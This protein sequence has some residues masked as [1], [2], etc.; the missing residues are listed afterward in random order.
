[1]KLDNTTLFNQLAPNTIILT[2][3][4][5]L[6][7]TLHKLYQQYQLQQG[8]TVWETPTIMPISTWLQRTWLDYTRTQF[9]D[10]PLLLNPQQEQYVWETVLTQAKETNQLLQIAETAELAKS[11]YG[12]L[13]QWQVDLNQPIFQSSDDYQALRTWI[14]EYHRHC[15][16]LNAMDSTTLID[17]IINAIKAKKMQTPEKIILMGFNELSPQIKSLLTYC[18]HET[19]AFATERQTCFRTTLSDFESEMIAMARWAKATLIANPKATIGCVIPTLDATRDR[20]EQLF[21]QVMSHDAIPFNIS[22]GKPLLAY[23]VL[24]AA[25]Q[26]LSIQQSNLSQDKLN[27]LLTTPFIG[28]AELERIQRAKF[29]ALLRQHNVMQFNILQPAHP[30][31]TYCNF[32]YKR[33]QRYFELFNQQA[34]KQTYTEWTHVFNELLTT[35]GWPGERSLN[36]EEFQVVDQWL[37]LLNN[38]AS[39]DQIATPTLFN[40]AWQTLVKMAS[41]TV[42]QAKTPEAPIQVLGVLEAAALPFDYV[43]IA[44]MDDISWPPQPKPN[45]FIP[46]RLQRELNMPHATPERELQYCE[47]LTRQFKSCASHV[48]FSSAEAQEELELHPSPLIRDLPEITLDKLTLAPFTSPTEQIYQSRMIDTLLDDHGPAIDSQE[49]IRGGISIL[50]Q[51]AL[52]PFKAFAEWRLHAKELEQP[53]PGLRAKDRGIIIHKVLELVWK[54]LQHHAALMNMNEDALRS[55]I[56]SN[57]DTALQTYSHGRHTQ[58]QYLALEKQRLQKLIWE[59]LQVEKSRAPFTVI[60]HEKSASITLNKLQLDIR[61]DRIDAL[62][63]GKKLIIDYKTGKYNDIYAWFSERPEEPQLPVYALLDMTNTIGITFAQVFP[64]AHTFKGISHYS[65]D[66]DG[67]KLISEIKK[68]TVQSWPAQLDQWQAI[69]LKLSDDFYNG[70]ATVDPKNLPETCQYC[71]LKSLCRVNEKCLE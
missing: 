54:S 36:S 42:F 71:K 65:L 24:N 13:Q 43:W 50:K 5:R 44:G 60:T 11:A 35:L 45:P 32:L 46:K 66:I 52:C 64:G 40:Q 27:F 28:E 10:A 58:Q 33:L 19:F 37:D 63:D 29:D 31:D 38:F 41:N 9:A 18:P 56:S 8:L 25:L 12:L 23:P 26:L 22:A 14:D 47:D 62:P 3:N 57:I 48:I 55:L 1:M 21:S 53:Q 17:L 51:Q 49:K 16:H 59:W 34:S 15:R 70:V 61:I 69:L 20:I 68:A 7:A 2:P 6:S 30:I 67:I 39:L 4:R